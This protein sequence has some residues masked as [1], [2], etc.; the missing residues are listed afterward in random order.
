MGRGSL[1][2][3]NGKHDSVNDTTGCGLALDW[4]YLSKRGEGV[5]YLLA[6]VG[7]DHNITLFITLL[8]GYYLFSQ[9]APGPRP[10]HVILCCF[11]MSFKILRT[12]SWLTPGH[13]RSTSTSVNLLGNP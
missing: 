6:E 2:A 7:H 9:V 12:M 1:G 13:T 5:G 3:G 8:R 11:C 4:E 10:E